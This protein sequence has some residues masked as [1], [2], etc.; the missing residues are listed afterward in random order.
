MGET[1]VFPSSMFG[2]GNASH[3]KAKIT[4]LQLFIARLGNN[5]RGDHLSCLPD[6]D[7]EHPKLCSLCAG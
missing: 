6:I 2:I 4:A 3:D 5:R 7:F 1:D